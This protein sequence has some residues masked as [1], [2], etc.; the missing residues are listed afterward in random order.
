MLSRNSS[1]FGIYQDS[2]VLSLFYASIVLFTSVVYAENRYQ[3]GEYDIEDNPRTHLRIRHTMKGDIK[4]PFATLTNLCNL[5]A[6][7]VILVFTYFHGKI[8]HPGVYFTIA[9]ITVLAALSW[10][11]HSV[12]SIANSWQ[13]HGDKF[14][15][16]MVLVWSGCYN[17]FTLFRTFSPSHNLLLYKIS[18]ILVFVTGHVGVMYI[19]VNQ[20]EYGAVDVLI[21]LGFVAFGPTFVISWKQIYSGLNRYRLIRSFALALY[22]TMTPVFIIGLGYLYQLK[23]EGVKV[24]NENCYDHEYDD[25]YIERRAFYD[26][27][28]G[29]W[30]YMCG[31]GLSLLVS[32]QADQI[33][34][35]QLNIRCNCTRYSQHLLL[36][37]HVTLMLILRFTLT[38][39]Q[40]LRTA[41]LIIS[42]ITIITTSVMLCIRVK[43]VMH[44][45]HILKACKIPQT[46]GTTPPNKEQDE[47]SIGSDD[48]IIEIELR[49]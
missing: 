41:I 48:S 25:F 43:E 20:G 26:M 18:S 10:G 33:Q 22:N 4:E 12:G 15:M 29:I 30:H 35:P 9:L 38:T 32:L 46:P 37:M 47:V 44:D 24:C 49:S 42:P 11:H 45:N 36:W 17:G 21:P 14:G 2:I 27:F 39:G 28:H 6:S 8:I 19:I 1:R 13:H 3:F 34:G 5:T 23:A 40:Q 16:Y 31:I 7:F